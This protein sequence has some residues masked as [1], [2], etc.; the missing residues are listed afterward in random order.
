MYLWLTAGELE[1]IHIGHGA[2]RTYDR[3]AETIVLRL[4]AKPILSRLFVCM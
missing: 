2:N 4:N 1:R 3:V